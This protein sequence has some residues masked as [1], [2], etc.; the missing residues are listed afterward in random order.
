MILVTGGTGFIG[1][2]TCVALAE[3]GHDFV[4]VDNFDNSHAGVLDG[5]GAAAA[6]RSSPR[7]TSATPPC[8]TA[9]SPSTRSVP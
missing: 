5:L 4:I 3:A 8:S 6:A 1:L 9:C 7:A 2:H